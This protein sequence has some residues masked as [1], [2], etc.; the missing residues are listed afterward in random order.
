MESREFQAI[1]DHPDLMD[2][3]HL[4]GASLLNRW[5]RASTRSHH[6]QEWSQEHTVKQE[7]GENQDLQAYRDQV[8]LRVSLETLESQ[9]RWAH[10]APEALTGPKESLDW[11]EIPDQQETQESRDIQDPRVPEDSLGFQDS[12]DLG[13]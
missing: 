13:E 1:Q 4:Q 3:P 12:Q 11:M 8:V 5:R 6:W 7:H 9:D 10:S 2:R